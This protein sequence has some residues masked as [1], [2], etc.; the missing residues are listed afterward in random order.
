MPNVVI[1]NYFKRQLKPL[2][3]KYRDLKDP[4]IE[5]LDTFHP[6][7]HDHIGNHLYKVRLSTPSLRRGKSGAF[8]LILLLVELD[9][10][11][12]PVTIY[13]KG[14]RESLL[15]KELNDHLQHVL[16]EL[17]NRDNKR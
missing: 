10:L 15:Q 5:T 11:L 7:L 6:D 12:V 4:M 14:D 9:D 8:R 2:V 16:F 3:K 17:D 13:F 1:L